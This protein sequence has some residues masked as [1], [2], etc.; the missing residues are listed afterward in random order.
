MTDEI[1]IEVDIKQASIERSM[2]AHETRNNNY[3]DNTR[4]EKGLKNMQGRVS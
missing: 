1:E 4:S 2:P 3:F